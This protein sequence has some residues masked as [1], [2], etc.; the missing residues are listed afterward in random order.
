M[1]A[2]VNRMNS[3]TAEVVPPP[4]TP[5][6]AQFTSSPSSTQP[7]P[8]TPPRRVPFAS[9]SLSTQPAPSTPPRHSPF[10][11][12]TNPS[13]SSKTNRR[14]EGENEREREI[15]SVQPVASD[16]LPT[17]LEI[18]RASLLYHLSFFPFMHRYAAISLSPHS[19]T[20]LSHLEFLFQLLQC[21][22][23]IQYRDDSIVRLF[24]PWKSLSRT[25]L[26][27]IDGNFVVKVSSFLHSTNVFMFAS[28]ALA[29]LCNTL[30]F[31]PVRSSL[32]KSPCEWMS[33]IDRNLSLP[34]FINYLL[35]LG[36]LLRFIPYFLTYNP[37]LLLLIWL[38]VWFHAYYNH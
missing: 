2:L 29:T 38:P 34:V 4:S 19:R 7:A 31:L 26:S 9:S 12:S 30:I 3:T 33:M 10:T 21:G 27:N 16:S 5:R 1:R 17:N 37:L 13:F 20:F 23:N 6:R 35:L 25:I 15:L 18:N 22:M 24:E 14:R 8:S 11:P 36:R 28:Q 32:N